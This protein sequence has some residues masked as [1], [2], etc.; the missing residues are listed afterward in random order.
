MVGIL[1][2]RKR[3]CLLFSV[4]ETDVHLYTSINLTTRYV[5]V[6]LQLV[7][8]GNEDKPWHRP[9]L[10][11]WEDR[12]SFERELQYKGKGWEV[13]WENSTPRFINMD[14]AYMRDSDGANNGTNRISSNFIEKNPKISIPYLALI[15]AFT[16]NGCVGNVM[17][18]GA[19]LVYKVNILRL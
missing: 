9:S 1:T 12:S 3:C 6:D 16:L 4:Y 5:C 2:V 13:V 17:V 10:C 7:Q 14:I 15:S 19:V 11:Q 18:I 8:V